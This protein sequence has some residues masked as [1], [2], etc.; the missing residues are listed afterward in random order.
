MLARSLWLLL[1][2]AFLANFIF[3]IPAYYQ[4]LRTICTA[5]NQETCQF[6]QPTPANVTALHR[7]GVSV[8]AYAAYFITVDVAV[9]LVFWIV[10]L[11]IF[12]RKSNEWLGLLVSF[13]LLFFGSSGISDT[14]QGAWGAAPDSPAFTLMDALQQLP[15]LIQWSSLGLFLVTFPTGR[16]APR[17]T[18]IIALLWTL[19]FLAFEISVLPALEN[20]APELLGGVVSLTYGSTAA[21]LLYRYLRVF[22]PTQRQQTKWVVFGIGTGV[23]INALSN[24]ITVVIPELGAPDA[25]YQ[26]LS[27]FFA[28]VLFL[29]IPLCIGIAI[30]R[31][32]LWDIDTLINKALVYGSLTAL[33]GALYAGLIIGLTSLADSLSGGHASEQPGALV[34]ST[35]AIAAL[36]QPARR[37]IQAL[38]DRRFY[39]QKYDA[40]KA[41]AA[42]SA[43]LRSETDLEQLRAQLLSI[44]NETMQPA[45]VSLWLRSPDQRPGDTSPHLEMRPSRSEADASSVA[46]P[47][48]GER[49]PRFARFCGR[50]GSAIP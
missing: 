23:S 37:R 47:G 43:A 4:T 45:H 6:W 16:F 11:L 49:L 50:C 27:G 13:V 25:P 28:A 31:Y 30:L 20:I 41:L 29:S 44:V 36:F 8:D 26:L 1:A 14:L 39:R 7:L 34:I 48:C 10:G 15:S 5:S 35:L 42:F 2:L 33:L 3:S 18:W 9:S 46:C 17:W 21:L 19:Q 38:I 24:I 12:W 22:T 32:R 40:E